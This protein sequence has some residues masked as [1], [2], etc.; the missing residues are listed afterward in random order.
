LA[1]RRLR[2][3]AEGGSTSRLW[4]PQRL[5]DHVLVKP[6]LPVWVRWVMRV[7]GLRPLAVLAA[8]VAV[9]A[10]GFLI[11]GVLFDEQWMA[12]SGVTQDSFAGQEWRMALSPVMPVLIAL[13]TGLIMRGRGITSWQAGLKLGL[14]VGLF[15]LVAGRAYMFVY[16]TEPVQ[17]LALDSMHLLLN[18][19]AAG[20]I[21]GAMR[22]AD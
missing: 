2:V 11:Y 7:L 12:W 1:L 14:M 9:Y 16:G 15:F 3:K 6:D 19:A 20:A 13:G 4:T 8:A 22:A 21:L 10:T 18:G 17:L 5:C